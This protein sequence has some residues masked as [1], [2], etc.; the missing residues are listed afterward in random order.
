MELTIF[1]V[2]FERGRVEIFMVFEFLKQN[3]GLYLKNDFYVL[4]HKVTGKCL[5]ST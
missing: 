3:P 1:G 2:K 5:R 4:K